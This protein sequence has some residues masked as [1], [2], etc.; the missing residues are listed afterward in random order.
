MNLS[1]SNIAWSAEEDESVY[2]LLRELGV[3]RLEI[4]PT[5][6]WSSPAEYGGPRNSD[7]ELSYKNVVGKERKLQ[8]RN[9]E[10]ESQKK[11]T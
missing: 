4:A 5:R 7:Q 6:L 1:V 10:N 2:S 8:N 11:K 3:S 9:H